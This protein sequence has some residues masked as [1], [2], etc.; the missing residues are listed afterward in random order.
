MSFS[1]LNK[2]Y[3]GKGLLKEVN[4]MG[5][6]PIGNDSGDADR[7]TTFFA[8]IIPNTAGVLDLDG[9]LVGAYI[10]D[11]G[12]ALKA[13]IDSP[14]SHYDP[15]A[16]KLIINGNLP[17]IHRYELAITSSGEPSINRYDGDGEPTIFPE[18][19]SRE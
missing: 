6:I 5:Y 8:G 7:D 3:G 13:K 4:E 16:E 1:L 11:D 2:N 14:T 15:E 12:I 18:I 19:G 17:S 9:I 10:G